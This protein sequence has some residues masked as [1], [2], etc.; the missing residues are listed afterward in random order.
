[1]QHDDVGRAQIQRPAQHL[2]HVNRGLI[3]RSNPLPLVADKPVLGVE[4]QQVKFLYA[5]VTEVQAAVFEQ[6]IEG[7]QQRLVSNLHRRQ[8]SR[9]LAH[10]R[11]RRNRCLPH[12]LDAD[13]RL[14]RRGKHFAEAAELRDQGLGQRLG[15]P[16]GQGGEQQHFQHLVVGQRLGTTADQA[17]AQAVPVAADVGGGVQGLGLGVAQ[18][19][20]SAAD[21]TKTLYQPIGMI[22]SRIS[23]PE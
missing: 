10:D 18:G 17:L 16:P 8:P 6:G 3:H 11:N 15:I 14:R 23:T 22:T 21:V 2:A 1:M 9:R 20:G 12:A 19:H 5:A 4:K 13:Q 7:R